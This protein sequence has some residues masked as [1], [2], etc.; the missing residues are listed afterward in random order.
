[1]S[2]AK[3]V[4]QRCLAMGLVVLL[5]SLVVGKG[6]DTTSKPASGAAQSSA[7]F[8]LPTLMA[9]HKPPY[10][11]PAGVPDKSIT[12]ERVDVVIHVVFSPLPPTYLSIG[13]DGSY[14]CNIDTVGT[15]GGK[16]RT[17]AR[18]VARLPAPRLAELQRLLEATQWLTAAG[19]EGPALHTDA[20]NMTVAVTRDGKA[21]TIKMEGQRPAPYAPLQKFFD[22]LAWQE[23][24]YHRLRSLPEESRHA[25]YELHNEIEGALGRPGHQA[26]QR[27]I[28]FDRYHELFAY[29]LVHWYSRGTDELRT[30]IDLMLLLKR[31]EHATAIAR[32][33]HDRD[34]NMR[35]T[36]ARALAGLMGEKA[37]PLLVEMLQSTQEARIAV[38]GIGEP[39]VPA[40]ASIIE[41]DETRE[42]SESVGMIRAYIDNW[43][44]LPK[45]IDPRVIT[46]VKLNVQRE[47]VRERG[48]A[49]HR[50]LLKL[51]GEAEPKGLTAVE[52]IQS[53]L[54][55][56]PAGDEAEL[57]KLGGNRETADAWLK[58]RES[59]SPTAELALEKLYLDKSS[60]LLMTKPF[61][62]K[63]GDEIRLFVFLGLLRGTDWRVGP[64][65]AHPAARML[66][67][68]RFLESHPDAREVVP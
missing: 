35:A 41:R 37:I 5:T 61:K 49:Y 59:F 22:D 57:Q 40:I 39:A 67:R 36:V 30:A 33:R 12:F 9:R 16:Q 51:A 47:K 31:T 53:W 62:D 27:E 46:A 3:G 32:L 63:A 29:M 60:G 64:A 24:I 14:F 6:P 66:Y 7:G 20:S 55:H 10:V 18:L 34:S 38:I 42:G 54:K 2:E 25:L 23:H 50:E 56:L 58:L 4:W 52:T 19:G 28:N 1:M 17:G 11:H 8:D 13:R 65:L 26:P 44:K 43:S 15:P 48:Y 21:R 45:P 68:D